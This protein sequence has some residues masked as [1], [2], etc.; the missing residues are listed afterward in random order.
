[1]FMVGSPSLLFLCFSLLVIAT[2]HQRFAARTLKSRHV[3]GAGVRRI[4]KCAVKG[5]RK[6]NTADSNR[7]DFDKSGA[8]ANPRHAVVVVV[9]HID[10]CAVKGK[11]E[12]T[13]TDGNRAAFD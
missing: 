3:V 2:P 13:T 1:M 8:G 10:K 9:R 5:K 11:R 7:A 6:W 12:W 4:D